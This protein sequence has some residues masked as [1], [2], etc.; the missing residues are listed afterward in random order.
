MENEYL[1]LGEQKTEVTEADSIRA[2]V[3]R[4][5]IDGIPLKVITRVDIQVGGRLEKSIWVRWFL[6]IPDQQILKRPYLRNSTMMAISKSIQAQGVIV[7][8]LHPF[9]KMTKILFRTLQ[10]C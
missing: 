10:K 4:K 2:S 7:Y 3:Y 8:N 1:Y 5:I 6:K 9:L